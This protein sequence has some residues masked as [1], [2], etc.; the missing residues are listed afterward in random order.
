MRKR[1]LAG[2]LCLPVAALASLED[3]QEFL[4]QTYAPDRPGASVVIMHE[5]EVVHQQGYGMANVEHGIPITP[6][7]I[8]RIGSV[9]K[10]FTGA[11]IMLLQ[12]RGELSVDDPITTYLP[13]YPTHGHEITISHLLTHTSGFPRKSPFRCWSL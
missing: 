5:G 9:T 3:A 2:L 13:D 4:D 6:E 10:Q 12:Q 7:T 8:F 11:A 1:F